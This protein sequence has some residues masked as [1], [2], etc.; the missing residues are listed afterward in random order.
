MDEKSAILNYIQTK[1][2]VVFYK[3]DHY[4]AGKISYEKD[5]YYE[6]KLVARDNRLFMGTKAA[7]TIAE[8]ERKIATLGPIT[9][10]YLGKSKSNVKAISGAQVAN[11]KHLAS[12]QY[13]IQNLESL[14]YVTAELVL[15]TPEAAK[16]DIL[17][18]LAQDNLITTDNNNTL[19][20]PTCNI[21]NLTITL[22]KELAN[23]IDA[24]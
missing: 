19:P 7:I 24:L 11:N 14:L 16:V 21:S 13:C 23:T 10:Y 2:I 9:M 22:W 17:L 6:L 1:P 15:L 18:T 12:P 8:V 5:I 20:L 3:E 4:T